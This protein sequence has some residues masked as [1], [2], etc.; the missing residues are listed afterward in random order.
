M[1]EAV[2]AVDVDERSRCREAQLHHRNEAHAAGEHLAFVAESLERRQCLVERRG[3][4]VLEI[5]GIHR[6]PPFPAPLTFLDRR[7]DTPRRRR[8]PRPTMVACR[9]VLST[10]SSV[11][12]RTPTTCRT[13]AS[14]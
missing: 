13:A 1:V 6:T 14:R 2:D 12:W 11:R 3:R 8:F 9:S 7:D 4:E 5:R 10:R